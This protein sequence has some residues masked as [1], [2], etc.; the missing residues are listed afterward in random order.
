MPSQLKLPKC[1]G[2]AEKAN[3]LGYL[4]GHTDPVTV[5][6]STVKLM[7]PL[8]NICI[9]N[10][11]NELPIKVLRVACATWFFDILFQCWLKQSPVPVTY[12]VPCESHEDYCIFSYPEYSETRKQ[13]EH[14]IIDPSH[15]LTNLR[16][17]ATTKGFFNCKPSA[18]KE[19]A[20]NNNDI[21]S[22]ALLQEPLPDK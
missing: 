4:L 19:V 15:C 16:L 13:I 14:R 7:L 17:H 6:S 12:T 2:K 11:K 5:K 1:T 22:H 10:I 20:D 3:C 18:F 21:L 9:N 8:R